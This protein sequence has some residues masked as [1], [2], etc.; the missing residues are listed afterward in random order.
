M[1]DTHH[2]NFFC[3][4]LRQNNLSICLRMLNGTLVTQKKDFETQLKMLFLKEEF[5]ELKKTF[6]LHFE[7]TTEGFWF[8]KSSYHYALGIH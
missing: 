7:K 1:E 6:D 3:D 4:A 2:V 5:I 8:L